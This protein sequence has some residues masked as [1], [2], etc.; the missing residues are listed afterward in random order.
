MNNKVNSKKLYDVFLLGVFLLHYYVQSL[1]LNLLE[2]HFFFLFLFFDEPLTELFSF[3]DVAG[4]FV[5]FVEFSVINYP[6]V[7]N[8]V[9]HLPTMYQE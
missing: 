6:P 3:T 4:F 1:F 9:R 8:D 2:T 5:I 7:Q